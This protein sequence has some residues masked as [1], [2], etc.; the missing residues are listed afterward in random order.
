MFVLSSYLN[1]GGV[2]G[3]VVEGELLLGAP[4]LCRGGIQ[5]KHMLLGLGPKFTPPQLV[6]GGVGGGVHGG[7][8]LLSGGG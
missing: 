8:P 7:E 3:G 4:S 5:L 1:R 6:H 2:P